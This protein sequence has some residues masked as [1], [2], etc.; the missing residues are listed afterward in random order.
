[1]ETKLSGN[2]LNFFGID[3]HMVCPS[4]QSARLT[5]LNLPF[6]EN[7]HLC[8]QEGLRERSSDKLKMMN[9]A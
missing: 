4:G 2:G 8:Q 1:M 5:F 6:L 7:L 9:H 3:E